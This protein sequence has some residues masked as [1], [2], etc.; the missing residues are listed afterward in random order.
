ME[1]DVDCHT[2]I[3]K[4]GREGATAATGGQCGVAIEGIGVWR[5]WTIGDWRTTMIPRVGVGV[6]LLERRGIS[7]DIVR[8]AY[9]DTPPV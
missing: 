2:G 1:G 9:M 8:Y 4:G 3:E 6:E 7:H 5:Y